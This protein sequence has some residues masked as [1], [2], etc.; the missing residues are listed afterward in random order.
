MIT[1]NNTEYGQ[2]NGFPASLLLILT[3]FLAIVKVVGLKTILISITLL[4]IVVYSLGSVHNFVF[5][6]KRYRNKHKSNR[7]SPFN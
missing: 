5:T 7:N 3:V 1:K 6:E 4:V 2:A